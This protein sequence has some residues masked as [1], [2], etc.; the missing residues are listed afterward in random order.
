MWITSDYLRDNSYWYDQSSNFLGLQSSFNCGTQEL[1]TVWD[2]YSQLV[3][4]LGDRV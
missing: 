2:S 4:N 3:D 1:S